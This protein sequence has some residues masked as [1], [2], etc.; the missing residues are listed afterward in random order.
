MLYGDKVLNIE[1]NMTFEDKKNGLKAYIF[2]KQK[3]FDEFVGKIYKYDPILNLQ[4]KEPTKI[5]EIKDIQKEICNLQGSWLKELIIDGKEYWNI[6]TM[7]PFQPIYV[8]NPMPSD[9]RYR[10]DLIWLKRE[11]ENHS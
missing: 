6:E 11:N 8:P 7:H 9:T 3:R 4:K 5:A 10:E 1:G 2:F